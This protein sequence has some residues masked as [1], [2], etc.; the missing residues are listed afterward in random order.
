MAAALVALG[1]ATGVTVTSVDQHVGPP[2]VDLTTTALLGSAF[3]RA[4]VIGSFEHAESQGIVVETAALVVDVPHP[5]FT[6]W[7]QES[8]LRVVENGVERVETFAACDAYELMVSAV[9]ARVR[10]DDAWVL[11]LSTSYDVAL[12]LDAITSAAPP[13]NPD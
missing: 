11:P 4:E 1:P 12:V 5:A 7:R 6:S 10:G 2:G 3:G 9:S 8:S 13:P